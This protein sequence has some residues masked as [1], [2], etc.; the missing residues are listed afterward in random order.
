VEIKSIISAAY[1]ASFHECS[2]AVVVFSDAVRDLQSDLSEKHEAVKYSNHFYF[3]VCMLYAS[4]S[5]NEYYIIK[6]DF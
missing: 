5:K 1:H 2:S 6:F 3:N 4:T